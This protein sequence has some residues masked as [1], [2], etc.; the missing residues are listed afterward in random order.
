MT[1]TRQNEIKELKEK[2]A[3]IENIKY[4]GFLSG[5]DL[6]AHRREIIELEEL[7]ETEK[8]DAEK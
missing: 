7:E 5:M 3:K 8:N 2:I 4:K 6:D 1:Q